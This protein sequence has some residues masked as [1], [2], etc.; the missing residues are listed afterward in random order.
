[1]G[2]IGRN[3]V[4]WLSGRDVNGNALYTITSNT[5][6]TWY[7]IYDKDNNKLGK[8]KTPTELEEKHFGIK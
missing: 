3:E 8:A 7:Y 5:D 6:R 2:K 4:V 1:M